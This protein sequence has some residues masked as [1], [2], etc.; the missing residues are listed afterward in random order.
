MGLA[1][2]FILNLGFQN[3]GQE[4]GFQ[5][6]FD[7][8]SHADFGIENVEDITAEGV[9]IE[10]T[11]ALLAVNDNDMGLPPDDDQVIEQK[12]VVTDEV[13]N[14]PKQEVVK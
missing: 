13:K 14:Q 2:F 3:C 12:E 11:I 8:S 5:N 4:V 7:K 1:V 6:T 9:N 10:E